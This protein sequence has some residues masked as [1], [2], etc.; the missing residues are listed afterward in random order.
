MEKKLIDLHFE[1]AKKKKIEKTKNCYTPYN[2]L[3][4]S[5]NTRGYND[6]LD[7][8]TPSKKESDELYGE[9]FCNAYWGAG[10][11]RED[12]NLM[13]AYTPLRQTIV[14]LICAMAGEL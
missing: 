13:S 11:K 1:W 3:C 4:Y 9:G 14:L 8:V 7:L 12:E 10:L 5:L 2:G 6:F